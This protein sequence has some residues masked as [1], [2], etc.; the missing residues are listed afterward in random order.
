MP[1]KKPGSYRPAEAARARPAAER[2]SLSAERPSSPSSSIDRRS[3]R[4][5]ERRAIGEAS[6]RAASSSPSTVTPSP[7]ISASSWKAA[8]PSSGVKSWRVWNVCS[9]CSMLSAPHRR[10]RGTVGTGVVQPGGHLAEDEGVV[11]H[12]GVAVLPDSV[13]VPAERALVAAGRARSVEGG[14]GQARAAGEGGGPVRDVPPRQE[15]Q[16]DVPVPRRPKPPGAVETGRQEAREAGQERRGAD[17]EQV[18]GG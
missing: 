3:L 15:R 14:G 8:Q 11:Q 1:A 6:V 5:S 12:P 9:M 7:P 2:E 10:G 16:V 18:E 13:E 17:T 4:R